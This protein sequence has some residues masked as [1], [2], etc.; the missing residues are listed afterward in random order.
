MTT[1]LVKG[2]G[3]LDR[4]EWIQRQEEIVQRARRENRVIKV[5]GEDENRIITY[6]SAPKGYCEHEVC[7][8]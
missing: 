8:R 7:Q 5:I 4:Y 2:R 1:S 6:C 3:R